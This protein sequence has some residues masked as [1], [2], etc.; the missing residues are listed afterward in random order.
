MKTKLARLL[1]ALL[2]PVTILANAPTNSAPTYR[3]T[4][5][6]AIQAQLDAARYIVAR[7]TLALAAAPQR[8]H[9]RIRADIEQQR[10]IIRMLTQSPSDE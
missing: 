5:Y 9:A 7:L 4:P 2:L 10:A 3:D 8:E 6:N 1:L